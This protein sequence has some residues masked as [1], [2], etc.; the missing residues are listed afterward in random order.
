ME[1]QVRLGSL[2]PE[3]VSVD[4]YTGAIDAA[5]EIASG[6]TVPMRLVGPADDGVWTYAA[7][8]EFAMTG[9]RGFTVR[10]LPHHPDLAT[11]MLPGLVAWAR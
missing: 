4:I 11:P 3:D 2:S 8:L 9:R 7:T 6:S 10:I 5:G 1:T